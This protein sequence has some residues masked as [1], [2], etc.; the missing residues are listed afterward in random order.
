MLLTQTG[1]RYKLVCM[2]ITPQDLMERPKRYDSIDG[3]GEMVFGMMALGFTLLGHLQT[4]LPAHSMWRNGFAGLLLMY[5]VLL[6]TIGI[7]HGVSKA[8][9]K[10]ITWPRTGYVKYRAGGKARK[11][12]WAVMIV[13]GIVSAA[14]AAVIGAGLSLLTGYDKQHDWTN[15]VW[16]GNVAINMAAYA[17]WIYRMER[18]HHWKWLILLFMVLGLVAIALIA[19]ADLLGLWRPMLLFV[20]LGWIASGIVTLYLY[21]RHTPPPAPEAE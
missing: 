18:H 11:S 6:A 14:I 16:M 10:H 21:V 12:L 17:F 3:T 1:W 15:C 13:V 9:K 4:V 7:M 5:A 19:P 8:I 2:N 20:G